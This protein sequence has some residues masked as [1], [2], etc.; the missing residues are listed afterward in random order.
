MTFGRGGAFAAKDFRHENAEQLLAS[1]FVESFGRKARVAID[2]CGERPG[3]LGHGLRA[4]CEIAGLLGDLGYAG[5]A[6]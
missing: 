4:R 2:G 1:N 6:C 3:H 5:R